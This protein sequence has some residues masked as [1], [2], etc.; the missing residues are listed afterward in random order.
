LLQVAASTKTTRVRWTIAA[1]LFFSSVINYVDRQTFSVLE[2]VLTPRFQLTTAQFADI[3][4]AFLIA[5]T[6]MYVGSGIFTDRFGTRFSLSFFMLWWS[7]ANALHALATSALGLGVFRFLLGLGE[8]GNFMASI[9]V[10][11]EWYPAKERAF[12]NG[13]INAGATIGAVLAPPLVYWLNNQFGWQAAFLFTGSLGLVWTFFWLRCFHLPA[14]HPDVS[15]AELAHIQDGA[16]ALPKE[17]ISWFRLLSFRQTWGLLLARTVSDPV[18]WFYLFWMPKF[19]SGAR[20]FSTSEIQW[21][22][23]WPYLAADFGAIGGGWL[24]G[25]LL[26]EGTR[27]P[28]AVRLMVMAV[29]ALFMPV[30]FLLPAVDSHSGVILLICLVAG[31]HM[32]WKTALMTITNDFY[33]S[34]IIGSIAGLLAFGSGIGGI[35]FTRFAAVVVDRMGYDPLFYIMG[36]LHPLAW[37]I[38]WRLCRNTDR[39]NPAGEKLS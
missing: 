36:V 17:R 35:L 1:L 23:G 8:S 4:N 2:P 12:V 33:P 13:L 37:L 19:L 21:M 32:A 16:A 38:V 15:A 14:Q 11:S 27:K 26:S 34:N 10:V 39:I 31:A 18:W 29:A 6:A 9:R 24:C 25:R 22:S 20:G 30:S 3:S 5:Y 28:F 7:T